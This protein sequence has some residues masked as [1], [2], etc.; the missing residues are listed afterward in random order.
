MNTMRAVAF[1]LAVSIGGGSALEA[2]ET[3]RPKGA[4]PA[5]EVSGEVIPL[6]EVAR[7]LSAE[8]AKLEQQRF[9][10]LRQKLDQLIGE[11]L[12]AQ[13][14]GRRASRW[15]SCSRRRSMRGRRVTDAG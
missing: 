15:S 9:E 5:A 4:A 6:A 8:L 12:L 3:P 1:A 14:A 11:R 10:L 7:A 2:Q 13:E